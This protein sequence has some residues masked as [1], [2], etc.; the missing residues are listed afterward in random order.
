MSKMLTKTVI[1][2]LGMF[3]SVIAWATAGEA[4][5]VYGAATLDR[6]G[7]VLALQKGSEVSAGDVILTGADGQVQLKML[8]GARVA[9]KPNTRFAIDEYTAPPAVN[10]TPDDGRS[11]NRLLQGSISTITGVIGGGADSNDNDPTDENYQ[12]N[13]P[14]ATIGIRGTDYKAMLCLR[15]GNAACDGECLVPEVR[16]QAGEAGNQ[17]PP[18]APWELY[19]GVNSGQVVLHNGA[20]G[21][22]LGADEYACIANDTQAPQLLLTPPSVLANDIPPATTTNGTQPPVNDDFGQRRA[23]DNSS[24]PT[25]NEAEGDAAEPRVIEPDA[26]PLPTDNVPVGAFSSGPLGQEFEQASN[27]IVDSVDVDGNGDLQ[28]FSGE[29]T[30]PNAAASGAGYSI[31]T[32]TNVDQGADSDTGLNWGRWQGGSM[33]INTDSGV[34]SEDLSNRSLHWIVGNG[35]TPQQAQSLTGTFAYSLV[36][37]TSSTDDQGNIGSPSAVTG[38]LT[39]DFDNATVTNQIGFSINGLGVQASG[40]GVIGANEPGDISGSYNVINVNG[41]QDPNSA[42]EF[43]GFFTPPAAAN[44][45]PD[46]AGLTYSITVNDPQDVG[47]IYTISGAAAFGDPQ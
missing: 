13:T 22:R 40:N 25:D 37:N 33:L 20:G 32:A 30:S 35:L 1:V 14:V 15:T 34:V 44:A 8:D 23:P 26:P 9:L 12:M 45:P 11:I 24:E 17:L 19:V 27:I 29:Y 38:N 39:A 28:G 43:A 10:P 46:G 5:F 16:P 18:D 42:G 41:S 31:N 21:L 47:G 3:C 2:L 4:V 36:G 6:G 7:S